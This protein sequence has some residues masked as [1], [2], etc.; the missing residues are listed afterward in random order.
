MNRIIWV[1]ALAI[2]CAGCS[3]SRDVSIDEKPLPESFGSGSG[4]ASA[5]EVGWRDWL[6]DEDL[7]A[8]V[9]EALRNNQDLHVAL[10]RLERSRASVRAA[11]GALFPQV[12]L[13]LGA[14]IRKFGLYTMDGAGNAETEI[15]PGK[16][17]P[18]KL[19]G[20][21]IGL[22]ASWELDL[23]GKL[24][25]ERQSVIAQYLAS[26]EGTNLVL[27]SLVADVASAYFDL[28]ALD[29]VLGVLKTS[30]SQQTRALEVLRLQ[31][32]AGRANELAVQQFEAQLADTRATER[33]FTQQ[34]VETENRINV[35]LGRYP[36]PVAR[37][38][39]R[40]LSEPPAPLS[41]GVPSD[42]LRHRP[43]IRAAEHTIRAAEF[44]VKAA[45][46][47]FFPSLNITAGAGYDAFD[48]SLLFRTPE[49]L[50]YG[51]AGQL[52]AP[53]VNRTA[54][55]A[56][57]ASARADQ[58]AALYDYQRTVL[59]AYTEVVNSLSDV[60]RTEELL[61]SRREQKRALEQSVETADALYRAGKAT[62]LE[63][64]LAQENALQADLDLVEAYRRRRTANLAVYKALG[65]GWH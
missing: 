37:N 41:T 63:V 18:E 27:S 8:L 12:D 51:A 36:Q 57:F 45:R 33:E 9:A 19:P 23:W 65:G 17:V 26:V 30:A 42:L 43:D 25:S 49:S 31:K 10:Q 35:L 46:A 28:L 7:E 13:G 39:E 56:Q 58:I 15:R 20:Y 50:A 64:L 32:A 29:H 38:R 54:L 3:T 59:V 24:R 2:T 1:L 48:T 62:Y 21:T 22:T 6:G 61:A 40:L 53:L 52:V 44:D 4:G 47:A 55:Q 34:V 5:A 14:S 16:L 60:R 11:T